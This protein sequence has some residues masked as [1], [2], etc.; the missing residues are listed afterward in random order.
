MRRCFVIE[1]DTDNYSAFVYEVFRKM[2]DD[3]NSYVYSRQVT[4]DPLFNTIP[5]PK[6]YGQ[7]DPL[8]VTKDR[9][10]NA[11]PIEPE[12]PPVAPPSNRIDSAIAEASQAVDQRQG[13]PLVVE[14]KHYTDGSSATGV[15]PL[16]DLSP[17]QQRQ[18]EAG[19][20]LAPDDY[21]F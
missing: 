11:K 20:V 2:S 17:D 4:E 13:D 6:F 3:A 14:T 15:A 19:N 10:K 12:F 8:L 7:L 1:A 5:G 21:P 9:I 16:P 18:Q